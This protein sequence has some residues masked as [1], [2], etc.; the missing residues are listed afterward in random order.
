MGP[1][2]NF[3]RKWGYIL[4]RSSVRTCYIYHSKP[5]DGN[6][7]LMGRCIKPV[8]MIIQFDEI[9]WKTKDSLIGF[10]DVA[11][12]WRK[13]CDKH[14]GWMNFRLGQL[15]LKYNCR[16]DSSLVSSKFISLDPIK[17]ENWEIMGLKTYISQGQASG[18]TRPFVRQWEEK[19]PSNFCMDKRWLYLLYIPF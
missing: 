6:R 4:Q 16:N 7:E 2:W 19:H 1:H 8:R 13:L 15:V 18:C 9:G 10:I 11:Q 12:W 17:W 14:R 5:K 3:T